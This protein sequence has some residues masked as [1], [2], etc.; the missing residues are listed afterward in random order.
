VG[1]STFQKRLLIGEIAMQKLG[2]PKGYGACPTYFFAACRTAA[3]GGSNSYADPGYTLAIHLSALAPYDVED[4]DW[5]KHVSKLADLV[6]EENDEA[7]LAWLK[8]WVPRC[9]R[10][11]PAQRRH[12]F[13]R[14][15]YRFAN[16]EGND[17]SE[18]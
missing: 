6:S 15:I 17:I 13:L 3:T 9:L 4:E 16:E 5:E 1:F 10:L 7:V 12:S 18:M 2:K 8:R 14:G 11:V